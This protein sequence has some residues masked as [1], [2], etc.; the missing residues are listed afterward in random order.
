M[1]G[2]RV[3]KLRS[4]FHRVED[5]GFAGYVVDEAD[6]TRRFVVEFILDGW[7]VKLA[8]ADAHVGEL[9]REGLGDGC[10]GFSFSLP[11]ASLESGIVAE[12]RLANTGAPVGR[13]IALGAA[14]DRAEDRRETGDVQW[15]GG[16]RFEG[17][18]QPK[19]E[20]MPT[21]TALIDGQPVAQVQASRWTQTN[22]PGARQAVPAFDLHLP[23]RFA[24]GRV[25]RVRFVGDNGEDIAPVPQT[26][27]A[28]ADGLERTLARIGGLE[29]EQLRGKLFDQMLPASLP[30]S[31]YARWRERF[32]IEAQTDATAAEHAAAS[33]GTPVAV[34]LLGAGD[35]TELLQSLEAQPHQEWIAAALPAVREPTAFDPQHLRTF[36]DEDAADCALVL[37]ALA[38]TR[39][40]DTAL[41][42]LTA[43]FRQFPGAEAAYADF[44]VADGS[45]APWPIALPAFD[46]ER[47]LEQG[48]CALLFAL[49]RA[50]AL[51]AA[52]AGASDLF[53][54]FN[55]LLDQD[56]TA[57]RSVIHL[58]G[59]LGTV[60]A[61]DVAAATRSLREA[62]A[63]HLRARGI[64]ANVTA[65]SSSVL[66]AV[67]V[68]RATRRATITVIIPVRNRAPLLQSC[69]ELIA[70]ALTE[71]RADVLIID[72]DSSDPDMLDYL[73]ELESRR[74][75]VVRVPGPFNFSRLNNI[76]AEKAHSDYLCLLNNDVQ[77]LDRGWLAEMLSRIAEP[78][79]GAV[80]ALLLWPSDVVQHGG[81]VLGPNF[82][83]A[84]AFN[85]RTGQDCGYADLLR[86][87]HECSAVTAACLMTR[88][89]D[90]LAVGGM[91]EVRFP[92]NFND[93][94]YCLRLRAAGKR[95]V[96]T[97]HARLRHLKLASRGR[98]SA[99]DHA[100]RFQP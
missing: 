53:R 98:D 81:V 7:P 39:L 48:Y 89:S 20:R 94:D 43:A 14:S 51:R 37:F 41:P 23:E 22:V 91:D 31:A 83:A 29:S 59:V 46:Y 76:A 92:V 85:D 63:T 1:T 30:F 3:E 40:T 26:F 10:Y 54:L 93:V 72:N 67:R 99:P 87:A 71:T 11:V 61:I 33:A 96:L 2:D 50:A 65:T 34:V 100:A 64:Q 58:P 25:R 55:C 52:R 44:D 77:A 28:F 8:R 62:S 19:G 21:I 79:V 5:T 86:V 78:D 15:V 88:R 80:G 70:P 27:V 56:T 42:R 24:D 9:A 32:P 74:M 38:G 95:V 47:M 12:A 69:L 84:H 90:Y 17:W 36:L 16:L 60:P 18:C 82:A 75:L 13:P 73:E 66:P 45:G 57:G 35:E 6:P 49:T 4:E 97:P 68:A